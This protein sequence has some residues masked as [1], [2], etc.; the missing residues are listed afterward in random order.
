MRTCRHRCQQANVCSR[1]FK[2]IFFFQTKINWSIFGAQQIPT[3]QK[4]MK[5]EL[6]FGMIP[7]W[8]KELTWE[9]RF[10][11]LLSMYDFSFLKPRN[12]LKC[13]GQIHSLRNALIF[14]PLRR[15]NRLWTKHRKE[16]ILSREW[17]ERFLACFGMSWDSTGSSS[18]QKR[19]TMTWAFW[20]ATG[21]IILPGFLECYNEM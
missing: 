18:F 15:S 19:E 20:K 3:F 12:L 8:T 13:A 10:G 7:T 4:T 16:T 14:M 17:Q 6:G 21:P 2:L 5:M 11:W 1:F 9:G